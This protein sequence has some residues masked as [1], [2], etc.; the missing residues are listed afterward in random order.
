LKDSLEIADL[1]AK[2]NDCYYTTPDS[3]AIKRLSYWYYF[4]LNLPHYNV[5]IPETTS[6]TDKNDIF[7]AFAKR[8]LYLLIS[9][10]ELGKLDY[11]KNEDEVMILFHLNYFISL[12]T[13]IFDNLAIH[14]Y[15][16]YHISFPFDNTPSRISLYNKNGSDFLNEVEKVNLNLRNHIRNY[17]DFIVL[18]YNLREQVIH[19]EGLKEMGFFHDFRISHAIL[20]SSDIEGLIKVCGDKPGPYKKISQ[21]GIYKYSID[22]DNKK[23]YYMNPYYFAR[24]AS[25]KLVQFADEY[26]RIEGF[27]KFVDTLSSTNGFATKC[28][29]KKLR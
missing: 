5:P 16:N 8:F 17:N 1:F 28:F 27:T 15:D 4:R 12:I 25:C 10:D 23:Y 21:W 26:M 14:T 29:N 18:I 6:L 20:I 3:K 11:F 2:D 9:A 22:Q 19:R 7:N 24:S 13:G